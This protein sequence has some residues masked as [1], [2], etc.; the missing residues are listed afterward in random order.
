MASLVESLEHACAGDELACHLRVLTHPALVVLD[1]ISYVPVSRDGAVLFFQLIAARHGWA[2]TVLTSTRALGKWGAVL[3]DEVMAA[4]LIDCPLHHCHIVNIRG[5]SYRMRA[6]QR[7]WLAMQRADCDASRP[8][9]SS[10][11]ATQAESAEPATDLPPDMSNSR[12]LSLTFV[13]IQR[14]CLR[15]KLP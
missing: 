3:R 7:L 12:L 13:T 15:L 8:A 11:I 1:E 9:T 10:P 5:D 14:N 4:A 2:S 6:H